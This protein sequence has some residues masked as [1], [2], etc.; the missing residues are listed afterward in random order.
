VI[1]FDELL[2]LLLP[3]C[4]FGVV[5]ICSLSSAGLYVWYLYCQLAL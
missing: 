4:I 1:W 2:R 5:V 3:G